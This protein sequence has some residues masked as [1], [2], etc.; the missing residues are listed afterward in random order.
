MTALGAT[1]LRPID[2]VRTGRLRQYLVLTK[3]RLSALVLLTTAVGFALGAEAAGGAGVLAFVGTIVGTAMAAGAANGF[4]QIAEA[5][6]DGLMARTR[7]RPLPAGAMGVPHAVGLATV[8]G[9]G[10]VAVLATMVNLG[11][12]GLALLT[13]FL[14]VLL[15]TPLKTRSTLNTLVGAVCGAIPPM[16]GWIGATG[17]LDAGAWALG[18]LLFVWQ[19]PH[20][21]ALAWLYRDDYARGGFAML[22]V[23]DPT[24]RLTGR[25]VVLTSLMLL[26]MALTATLLGLAGWLYTLGATLLGVWM[27]ARG[28]RLCVD[29]TNHNARR[30]FLASLV[31]LSTLLVLLVLD[32]GPM[33]EPPVVHQLASAAAVVD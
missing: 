33:T 29:R 26:P 1:D 13:I 20:F 16:I 3:A 12:A 7:T 28:V 32:R 21:L 5:R 22:P 10:G 14:Y 25:I 31:Y 23:L 19:I 9:V 17:R 4:N 11:A 2:P 15:Y 30:V 18:G 6:R 24:G 8:L 27:L